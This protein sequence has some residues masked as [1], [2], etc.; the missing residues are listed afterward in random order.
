VQ[1]LLQGSVIKLWPPI[2]VFHDK[3]AWLAQELMPDIKRR[4]EGR[5]IIPCCRLDVDFL[6]R[7][8]LADFAIHHAI[9]GTPTCQTELLLAGL[10][11]EGI[12][13]MAG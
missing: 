6:E 5:A 2:G 9:H 1:R 13:D 12:E 7:R 3:V 11:I 10:T 4:A 8:P